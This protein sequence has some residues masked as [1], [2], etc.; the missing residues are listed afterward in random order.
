MLA[1][2]LVVQ[3]NLHPAQGC[4]QAGTILFRFRSDSITPLAPTQKCIG[5]IG[6]LLPGAAVDQC[7]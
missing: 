3:N 5:E 6:A 4:F 1:V 7:L 2:V